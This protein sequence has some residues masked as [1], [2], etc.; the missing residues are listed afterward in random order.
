M[1]NAVSRKARV[2]GVLLALLHMW[3]GCS[4]AR[5]GVVEF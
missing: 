1:K 2:L 5:N 4:Q 3:R